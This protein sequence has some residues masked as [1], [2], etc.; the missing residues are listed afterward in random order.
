M[1]SDLNQANITLKYSTYF[2]L[3]QAMSAIASDPL[4]PQIVRFK[5]S[6]CTIYY[7]QFEPYFKVICKL[8]KEV[9]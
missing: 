3:Q 9:Q 7:L 2:V 4:Y 1:G 5:T 6:H 8:A